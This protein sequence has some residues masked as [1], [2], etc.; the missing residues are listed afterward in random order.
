MLNNKIN[1]QINKKK[2]FLCI[3]LDIDINKIPK[4][5]LEYDDPIF[6]FAKQIINST[7]KY[8]IAYKPNIAFFEAHGVDGFRSLEKICKYLKVNYPDIFTIADAKRGDIGNT[9][10]MY[11]S[12]F[13]KD[14]DF[15]SIT[16]S[17]YM[18]SDSVEPFLTFDNKYV[19]LLA[20]TSNKGS[21]DFQELFLDD[22]SSKLYEKVINVSKT[23]ANNDRIMYVIG[24]KNTEEIKNVR[25]LVP[26]SYLLIPG[27]GAQ[28]GNLKEICKY[29]LDKDYKLIVN[30]SRSII[31]ASADDD[32][33][34]KAA[35]EAKNIQNEMESYIDKL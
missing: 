21:E 35:L 26:E 11:A 10:K 31:Y 16:V 9:S 24:A 7:N 34:E 19:F 18:G 29:G 1:S 12:A 23:W 30:S 6:E 13:L 25:K 4:L 8:A 33:A 14:L 2:S 15:D 17:P 3:G 27:V 20:L 28:G 22:N 5:L 32:F